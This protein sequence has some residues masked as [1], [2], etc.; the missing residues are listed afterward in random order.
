[1]SRSLAIYKAVGDFLER[2]R[3]GPIF[4]A[5]PE[6]GQAP[7]SP[8]GSPGGSG[9]APVGLM[10]L[11]TFTAPTSTPPTNSAAYAAAGNGNTVG[12]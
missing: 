7:A 9:P 11:A 1:M 10:G 3:F 8:D 12:A 4:E 6:A 5:A 2:R